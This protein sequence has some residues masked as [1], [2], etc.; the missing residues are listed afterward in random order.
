MESSTGN[1]EKGDE[2]EDIL[3]NGI[4]DAIHDKRWK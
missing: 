2:D 1:R 4:M 3:D